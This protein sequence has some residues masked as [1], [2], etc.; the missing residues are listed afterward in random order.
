MIEKPEQ[1][2]YWLQNQNQDKYFEVKEY[3]KRRSLNAN[4][5]CWTLISKIAEVIGITKED[6]YRKFIKDKG[7]YR[8]VTIDN[9]AA[10]TFEKIWTEKGLGW[11]CER[12]E[13]A[14]EGFTDIVAYYGSSVYD[15]KQMAHFID[16]IVEE[17]KGLEI[18]TLP[19]SEIA[20]LKDEWNV[21]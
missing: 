17:A 9:R 8:V 3:R 12:S 5:Y 16:Y 14:T 15:T 19:P 4:N 11:I 1:L 18:E 6:V 7:I 13:N 20:R 10:S 2:I 21:S